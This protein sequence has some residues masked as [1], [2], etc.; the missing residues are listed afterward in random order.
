MVLNSEIG[1]LYDIQ[2]ACRHLSKRTKNLTTVFSIF[3]LRTDKFENYPTLQLRDRNAKQLQ[4]I[5]E[6]SAEK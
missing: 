2:F 3:D 4:E 1:E 5:M 6:F